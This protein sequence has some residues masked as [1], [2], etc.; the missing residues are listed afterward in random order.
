MKKVL[1]KYN[2]MPLLIEY[3]NYPSM[4]SEGFDVR[5]SLLLKH[6]FERSICELAIIYETCAFRG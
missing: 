4:D 2:P 6:Q 1:S 3:H 5:G